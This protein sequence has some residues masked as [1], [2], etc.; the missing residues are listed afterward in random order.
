LN[1]FW[2]VAGKV[3][4]LSLADG[5]PTEPGDAD[6]VRRALG[7]DA[8][9]EEV[10]YRR[11]VRAVATT[12]TRLLSRS[13]EAEDVVQEAFLTAFR[14]LAR[15]QR[16]ESFRGWLLQIAV[17]LVHRRFRRRA[18]LRSL[19]LDRGHDDATLASE[20]DRSANAEVFAELSTIDGVLRSL[21]SRD[22]IAWVLRHVEGYLLDEIATACRCSL[23]TAKARIGRA[24]RRIAEHVAV[25]E[26]KEE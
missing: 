7:G 12:V 1:A 5:A 23:A 17:R 3:R 9:S 18:L 10:L 19:G 25:H 2:A 21:P 22:R 14:D 11:H 26:A 6:C 13:H 4:K 15:L 20:L 8:W 16:A 24:Q